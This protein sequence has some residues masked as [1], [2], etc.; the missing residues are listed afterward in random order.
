MKRLYQATPDGYC[1]DED[2]GQTS[3]WYVFSSLGFYPVTPGTTQYVIGSPL[4]K[5]ATLTMEDGKK[6][7]IDAPASSESNLYI[8][9]AKLNGK[10]YDKTYL[11]HADIQ[12]GG[13]V[14]FDLTGKPSKSW[15]TKPESGSILAHEVTNGAKLTLRADYSQASGQ[16]GMQGRARDL[17]IPCAKQELRTIS[18]QNITHEAITNITLSC[19]FLHGSISRPGR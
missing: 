4:F 10:A 12:K 1:G 11:E 3:A 18:T 5:K 15:G 17:R 19:G 7:T 2:N 9:G 13:S 16:S 6:F 8:Q 14:Q